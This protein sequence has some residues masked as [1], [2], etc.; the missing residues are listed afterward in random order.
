MTRSPRGSWPAVPSGGD[1]EPSGLLA[2]DGDSSAPT[3]RR[4]ASPAGLPLG[5]L[6]LAHVLAGFFFAS[7]LFAQADKPIHVPYKRVTLDNGLTVILHEDHKL[8]IV[9]VNTWYRVG[10]ANE[11][12]GRTGFAHLFEH[13]MFMGSEHVPTGE[14]DRLL[15]AAGGENNASTDP[16]RTNYYELVPKGALELALYLDADRMATLGRAMTQEKLDLQRDVVKNERRQSYENRPYGL[17]EET[18]LRDLFPE[19]HPYHWPTIG[20]MRDLDAASLQ[21]VKEF[22]ASYYTPGNAILS[23]AG[24]IDTAAAEA[25]VRKYFSGIPAGPQTPPVEAPPVRAPAESRMILEDRVELPRLTMAWVTPAEYQ[26]GDA[27]LDILAFVLSGD[28]TSRLYKR[29]VYDLQ[30]AQDVEA[31]Q[32]SMKLASMFTISITARPGHDLS[33]VEKAAQEEIDRLRREVPSTAEVEK[34]KRVIEANFLRRLESIG[35][36]GGVA[37]QLAAYEFFRGDPD[38]FEADRDRYRRVSAEE[39]RGSAASLLPDGRRVVLSVVPKGRQDLASARRPS[40]EPP[41]TENLAENVD[42]SKAPAPGLPADVHLSRV[43]RTRLRNGL[44]LWVVERHE[45]PIVRASLVFLAGAAQDPPGSPGLASLTAALL[46][47]GT[48]TRSALEISSGAS[49]LGARLSA[50]ADWDSSSLSIDVPSARWKDAFDLFADVAEHPAF[51]E[52]EIGRLKKERAASLQE[53]LAEPRAIASRAFGLAVYGPRHP[54]GKA[55]EG[56]LDSVRAIS[57]KDFQSFSRRHFVPGNAVLIIVGDVDPAEVSGRVEE[58][59]GSWKGESSAS[60]APGAPATGR[61]RV[62][63]IDKPGA[64]QSEIRVGEVGVARDTPDYFALEVMN[65]MLGGSFTSR[66]NQNLRETHGYSY[67]AGSS[68]SLRK[69]AGPFLV[70]AAVHT[71]VTAAALS[72]VFKELDRIEREEPAAGEVA[73]AKN[74]LALSFPQTLETPGDLAGRLSELAVYGLPDDYFESYVSRMGQVAASDVVRVARERIH[75]DRMQVV[76]VGDVSKIRGGIEK[77]KLGPV[78]IASYDAAKGKLVPVQ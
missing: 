32:N 46:P 78:E 20:S 57:R 41:R 73:K 71:E 60:A 52:E 28:K 45:V 54:Y 77:L 24:D 59:F 2:D 37:D 14:F 22:F 26:P 56:T 42:W 47:L 16:D 7:S 72:E 68:F 1:A 30:I 43:T 19:G 69:G 40:P 61:R 15:E 58:S 50:G 9:A 18:L 39:L 5:P 10:S 31:S 3:L 49:A 51:S 33:E 17:T 23:L 63:L 25:L 13:L 35:G 27:A 21:E 64:A 12:P 66:L 36:F 29:L 76:V 67:G 8:P 65:T 38:G 74:L 11:R 44:A 6:R 4:K 62:V 48:A 75:L 55:S 53:E 34:A 70:R